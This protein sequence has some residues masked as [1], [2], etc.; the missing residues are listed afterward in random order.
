N[1]IKVYLNHELGPLIKINSLYFRGNQQL[2]DAYLVK[3]TRFDTNSIFTPSHY[4]DI[5][6][7]LRNS[8]FIQDVRHLGI[9]KQEDEYYYG[10]EV[11][12]TRS[13]S[14]DLIV[15]FEPDAAKGNKFVGNGSLRLINLFSEGSLAWLEF[16]KLT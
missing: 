13:S 7:T 2:S 14:L 6:I 5:E 10:F 1:N 16:Q 8:L 4:S 15:G 12:E 9:I 3:L 11:A